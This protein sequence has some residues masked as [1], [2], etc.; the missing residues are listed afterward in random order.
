MSMNKFYK[1]IGKIP[2]SKLCVKKIEQ[3]YLFG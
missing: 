1:N 3:K 2:L